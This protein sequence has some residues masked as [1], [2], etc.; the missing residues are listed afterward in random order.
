MGNQFRNNS[1]INYSQQM[2]ESFINGT[3]AGYIK[4][5]YATSNIVL[6]QGILPVFD[7]EGNIQYINL[8][9]FEG[10]K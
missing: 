8:T 10:G 1:K 5:I 4:G 7:N 2:N 9:K 6:E 3:Q